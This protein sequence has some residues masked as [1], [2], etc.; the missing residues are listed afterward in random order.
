MIVLCRDI[1]IGVD[2]RGGDATSGDQK[3][4]VMIAAHW[5][6]PEVKA[7]GSFLRLGVYWAFGVSLI[8]L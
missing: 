6:L 5:V 3:A 2:M 1:S 8:F 4:L 7:M